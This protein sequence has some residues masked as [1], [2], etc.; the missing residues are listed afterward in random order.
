[1]LHGLGLSQVMSHLGSDDDIETGVGEGERTNTG[2]DPTW[3][4]TKSQRSPVHI[5]ACDLPV[6]TSGLSPTLHLLSQRTVPGAQ[7]QEREP[8][9][10]LSAQPANEQAR[11]WIHYQNQAIKTRQL[12]IILRHFPQRQILA[13]AIFQL[14]G[15]FAQKHA[16]ALRKPQ[17]KLK[18]I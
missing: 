7:V 9:D 14:P 16:L 12:L 5:Q 17:R 4:Q 3:P 1:M 10:A 8:R 18:P 11:E 6:P 15:A 13:I 2:G